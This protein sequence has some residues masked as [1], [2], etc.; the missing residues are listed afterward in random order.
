[1]KI[2]HWRNIFP[3]MGVLFFIGLAARLVALY[4]LHPAPIHE[5]FAPFVTFFLQFPS[6]D[7]WTNFL[8]SGAIKSFPYGIVMLALL[9]PLSWVG[10]VCNA[11]PAAVGLGIG[12]T[13]LLADIA[14][15]RLLQRLLPDK[16]PFL[17][18][19]WWLSPLVLATNLWVGQLDVVPIVLLLA[20]ILCLKEKRYGF[21]GVFLSLALSAKLSMALAVPLVV[22]YFIRN[23]RMWPYA[24]LF[25]LNFVL[26]TLVLL[27]LP[28]ISSGYNAMTL[29][30]SELNR[31]FDLR[32][33]LG[34][35]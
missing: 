3:R 31:L 30:T 15:L 14:V 26:L 25:F 33:P 4:A 5:W 28:L 12:A 10:Y 18:A 23:K 11:S 2:V 19:F 35:T 16:T 13:L 6:I 1:M 7:P 27:G 17:M 22:L 8:Q 21:A 34:T 32:L 20:C 9:T 24:T 29:G